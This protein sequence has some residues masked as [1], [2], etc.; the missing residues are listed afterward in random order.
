MM[1]DDA[2][3]DVLSVSPEGVMPGNEKA[4]AS[5][6]TTTVLSSHCDRRHEQQTQPLS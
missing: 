5:E 3:T 4:T 1:M 2:D 6:Q